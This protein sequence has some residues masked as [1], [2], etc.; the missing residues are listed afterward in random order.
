MNARTWIFV[1]VAVVLGAIAATF[2]TD[3]FVAAPI[4]IGS[5]I[6]PGRKGGGDRIVFYLDREYRLTSIKV[7]TEATADSDPKAATV[8]HLAAATNSAPVT[9]FGYGERVNGMKLP[10]GSDD[11]KPLKPGVQYRLVVAAGQKLG[12]FGFSLPVKP[13]APAK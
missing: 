12:K 13:E 5:R 3:W 10:L 7:L 9:D 1:G 11:P 2:F 4:R 6:F 8:W